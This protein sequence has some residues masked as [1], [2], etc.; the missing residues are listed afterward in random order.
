MIFK[1]IKPFFELSAMYIKIA[2]MK[3]TNAINKFERRIFSKNLELKF[4]CS[5][6]QNNWDSANQN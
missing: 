3:E 5:L 6:K 1:F 4:L 2:I